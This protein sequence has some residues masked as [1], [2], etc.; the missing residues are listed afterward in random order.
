MSVVESRRVL[1]LRHKGSMGKTQVVL[2]NS[3]LG[4]ESSLLCSI[5]I[6]DSSH[7]DSYLVTHV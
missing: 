2:T 5:Y 6:R 3:G 1:V 4:L 7:Y